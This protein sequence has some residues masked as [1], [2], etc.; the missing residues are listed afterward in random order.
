MWSYEREQILV[1]SFLLLL[2]VIS[3]EDLVFG[4]IFNVTIIWGFLIRLFY[5]FSF[6]EKFIIA[7]ELLVQNLLI[8][9]IFFILWN[10]N[11]FGG[12]DLKT[13]LLFLVYTPAR[14]NIHMITYACNF[15]DRTQFFISF[16]LILIFY[17]KIY[18][19]KDKPIFILGPI[20][21]ISMGISIIF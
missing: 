19:K 11:L 20:F 12:G 8:V 15:S 21:L 13:L 14:S 2:V 5:F 17:K 7:I 10:K 3:V 1:L 18:V 4:K 9:I 6:N 16:L